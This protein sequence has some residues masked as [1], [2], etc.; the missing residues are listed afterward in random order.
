MNNYSQNQKE[1]KDHL[2]KLV[3]V[4]FKQF[5]NKFDHFADQLKVVDVILKI[6]LYRYDKMRK[7]YETANDVFQ[8]NQNERQEFILK[9][10]KLDE[11]NSKLTNVEMKLLLIS[12][13]I[14]KIDE[15]INIKIEKQTEEK[16]NI[17][18]DNIS[19]ESKKEIELISFFQK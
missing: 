11:I 19:E 17:I 12:Q 10:I 15:K 1:I 8:S 6:Y 3:F 18:K 4:Y 13:R 5:L 16:D 7:K 9:N 14:S 2:E